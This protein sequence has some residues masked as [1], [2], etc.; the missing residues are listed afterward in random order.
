M[1]SATAPVGCK[2]AIIALN[3]PSIVALA[4]SEAAERLDALS[5]DIIIQPGRNGDRKRL[6]HAVQFT[7]VLHEGIASVCLG[8]LFP[9]YE[10]T[11]IRGR[12][13]TETARP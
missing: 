8:V 11:E 10:A 2:L 7:R 3:T 5:M 4:S 1:T 13:A 9:L 6:V 12:G